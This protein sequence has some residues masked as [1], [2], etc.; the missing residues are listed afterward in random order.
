MAA[1]SMGAREKTVKK[2]MDAPK[3]MARSAHQPSKAAF[4]R[5]QNSASIVGLVAC[6]PDRLASTITG[7]CC[8]TLLLQR[9]T[10]SCIWDGTKPS[11]TALAPRGDAGPVGAICP[12]APIGTA[13]RLPSHCPIV[14]RFRSAG[15]CEPP[16]LP[17][18]CAGA[19]PNVDEPPRHTGH[20]RPGGA[21]NQRGD[22]SSAQVHGAG[23]GEAA[24]SDEGGRSR[25]EVAAP[26][27]T[28][29]NPKPPVHL[30]RSFI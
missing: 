13:C 14:G 29:L 10:S 4:S 11:C 30:I 9:S 23:R 16:A 5:R 8:D 3:L 24:Q 15:P 7:V 2:A 21:R 6:L 1:S 25:K 19:I 22:C 28:A 26:E 27:F 18:R 20:P 12:E 17:G